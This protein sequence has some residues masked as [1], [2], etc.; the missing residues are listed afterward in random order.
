MPFLPQS[1]PLV[2]YC[3]LTGSWNK[4]EPCFPKCKSLV[5]LSHFSSSLEHSW[6]EEQE[7]QKRHSSTKLGFDQSKQ[8]EKLMLSELRAEM[9]SSSF[10]FSREGFSW[11][12][13]YSNSIGLVQKVRILERKWAADS[14]MRNKHFLSAI[15]KHPWIYLHKNTQI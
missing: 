3:Q 6:Q 11:H 12:K 9:Q 15:V 14:E 2:Y 7:W 4:L 1:S 5:H 13:N 10:H 8:I